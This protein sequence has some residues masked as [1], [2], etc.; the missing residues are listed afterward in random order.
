MY[1]SGW[2]FF[3]GNDPTHGLV[4]FVGRKEG[5]SSK[6]AYVQD[7]GTA[8]IA[9]DQSDG[10]A[11]GGKRKS[12]RINTHDAFERGLFIADIYAMPHGCSVWPAYWS[13]GTGKDWPNAGEIDIIGESPHLRTCTSK[14]SCDIPMQRV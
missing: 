12:I 11:S 5:N 4:D 3:T 14:Y 9:V 7:D 2:D 6:L 10:I 8:V 1:S 13:L